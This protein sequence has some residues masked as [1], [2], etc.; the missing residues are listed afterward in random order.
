[1]FALDLFLVGFIIALV[2]FIGVMTFRGFHTATIGIDLSAQTALIHSADVTPVDVR[3]RVTDGATHQGVSI[4]WQKPAWVDIVSSVPAMT[5]SGEVYLG[6]MYPFE[7]RDVHLIVRVKAVPGTRI[8]VGGIVHQYALFGIPQYADFS[9]GNWMVASS[10]VHVNIPVKAT[11]V[12]SGGS[13]PLV[14]SNDSITAAPLE[15]LRLTQH[16]GAPN[17]TINNGDTFLTIAD[18]APK[19]QRVVFV[20]LGQTNVT[21]VHLKWEL[22]DAAQAVDAG[23]QML[24]VQPTMDARI[25]DPLIWFASKSLA[26]ISYQNGSHPAR[27]FV[28]HPLLSDATSSAPF[29][30]YALQPSGGS[31]SLSLDASRTTSSSRW[32]ALPIQDDE[33]GTIFGARS[34]G[35]LSASVTFNAEARYYT[36]AG[37]QVGIGPLP[38]HVGQTTS[39]WI[40]WSVGPT[41][42]DLTNVTLRAAL[43]SH[44]QATGKFASQFGGSFSSDASSVLWSLPVLSATH[45]D[46]ATFAFEVALNP[47]VDQ[48]GTI[49]TIVNVSTLHATDVQT[50]DAVVG[51]SPVITAD[52]KNDP[53]VSGKGN[54]R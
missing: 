53:K 5:N 30:L 46:V 32:S 10:A 45:G 48:R 14:V 17:A 34:I 51:M 38:P 28:E 2:I 19:S 16:D 15:T 6:T 7:E 42:T 35:L 47:S 12:I 23:E 40:V 25:T 37:D 3:V 11:G 39:Y 31:L 13:V 54:V 44:V 43:P 27:I 41:E 22:Q 4:L 33:R 49:P 21:S 52:L 26:E 8:P 1:M 36:P 18:L 20:D 24:T 29:R 50:N 9:G